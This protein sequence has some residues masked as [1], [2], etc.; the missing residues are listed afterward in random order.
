MA[1]PFFADVLDPARYLEFFSA[2]PSTGGS[3]TEDSEL[4]ISFSA[5]LTTIPEPGTWT[6]VFI[7]FCM[8]GAASRDIRS[9]QHPYS[10]RR[11]RYGIERTSTSTPAAL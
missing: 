11:A 3:G 7:G 1:T 5:T 9:T 4:P 6:L 2:P 8:L 10:P